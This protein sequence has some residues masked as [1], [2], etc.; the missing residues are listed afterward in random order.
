MRRA[1]SLTA[2][3]ALTLP[4][5][6]HAQAL[7]T[8][9]IGAPFAVSV[10]PQYP[11]PYSEATVSVLSDSIDLA[12][13]T[14]TVTAGGTQIYKGNVQPTPIQLGRAGS[15]TRVAVTITAGGTSAQQT[16]TIQPQD[17]VLVA[18]PLSSAPPLY[19]GKPAIPLEGSVRVVAVANLR[20]ADGRATSPANYSY[21]WTVDGAAIAASSGIGKNVLVVA[22]PLQ[23]RER[24]VSVVVKSA[25]GALAGG[26]ALTL[27]PEE[28][29]VRVYA[30]DPLLGIR[31]DRALADSYAIE[32]S[33]E[34]FYAAAFSFP[35]LTG[36]PAIRW[37]VNG[38]AAQTGNLITLRPGG[39]G[40]GTA[41]LSL[42]ASGGESIQAAADFSLSFGKP[43]GTL[44][45][46]GL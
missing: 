22:A 24:D 16:V 15:A 39:T 23:Y 10:A 46:F 4:L 19:P 21:A 41:R 30:N 13:A 2:L 45:I 12:A 33:E 20:G 11:L 28:P 26:A 42:T 43:T 25:D 31:Y 7:S 32:G 6:A 18:E 3:L 27:I 34:T 1:L 37:F 29:L 5:A 9:P 17:V 14:M 35:T 40:E 36:A 38:E 8:V 44:G